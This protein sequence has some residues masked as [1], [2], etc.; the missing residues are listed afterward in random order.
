MLPHWEI[1]G[2]FPFMKLLLGVFV[3]RHA[4]SLFIMHRGFRACLDSISLSGMLIKRS[5]GQ[6]CGTQPSKL[7]SSITIFQI[8]PGTSSC[9]NEMRGKMERSRDCFV[10][11]FDIWWRRIM[12]KSSNSSTERSRTSRIVSKLFVG[13]NEGKEK[14]EGGSFSKLQMIFRALDRSRQ[15]Y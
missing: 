11:K 8:K 10:V 14:K 6:L 9:K 5:Q 15:M 7:M 13:F 12:R 1:F 2:K 3:A 4:S